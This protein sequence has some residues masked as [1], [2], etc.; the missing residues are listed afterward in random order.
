MI[1]QLIMNERFIQVAIIGD[2]NLI[3]E[4]EE[5]IKEVEGNVIYF[6]KNEE[7]K[8]KVREFDIFIVDEIVDEDEEKYFK[9][10]YRSLENSGYM[11]LT[12]KFYNKNRKQF[13]EDIGFVAVNETDKYITA[14]KMHGWGSL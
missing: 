10:I 13:L 1:K 9:K 11:I 2:K 7:F 3:K 6:D 4:I 5:K 12:P 14:K 8:P